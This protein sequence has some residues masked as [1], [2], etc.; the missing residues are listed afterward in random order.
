MNFQKMY[1]PIH[2]K[3][4]KDIKH[5]INRCIKLIK[6]TVEKSVNPHGPI[7]GKIWVVYLPI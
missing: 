7:R 3:E 6:G 4:M 5:C 1:T 2:V